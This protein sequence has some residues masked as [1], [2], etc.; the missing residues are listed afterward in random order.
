MGG[1][2][3][4]GTNPEAVYLLEF[5]VFPGEVVEVVDFLLQLQ[6]QEVV[7]VEAGVQDL[8]M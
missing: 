2:G 1:S 6:L 7:E 4:Y 5:F 3:K 8:F